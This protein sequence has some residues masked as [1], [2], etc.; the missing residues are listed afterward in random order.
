[1]LALGTVPAYCAIHS[2]GALRPRYGL[3]HCQDNPERANRKLHDLILGRRLWTRLFDVI[4][5]DLFALMAIASLMQ[6]H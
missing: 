4:G 6:L 2:S 5:F 3:S 1:V